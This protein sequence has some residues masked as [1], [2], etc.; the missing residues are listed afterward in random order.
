MPTA[1]TSVFHS[2]DL[3]V[4][5]R[6]HVPAKAQLYFLHINTHTTHNSSI[7]SDKGLTLETSIL[8]LFTVDNLRY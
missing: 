3:F 1:S 7:C 5:S 4:F 6:F 2:T 8:K